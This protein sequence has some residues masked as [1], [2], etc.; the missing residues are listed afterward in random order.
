LNRL[1]A[2]YHEWLFYD[3]ENLNFGKPNEQREVSLFYGRDIESLQYAME[4]AP[5][6]NKRFAY[7]P[8][9]DEMLQSESTGSA[10]G[11]PDLVHAINA[12]NT[13]YSKTF[14]QPSLVRVDNGSDIKDHVEHEEKANI[15]NLLK[16]H[17]S[18]DNPEVGI[19]TIADITMS[20]K[21]DLSFAT[22]SLGKFLI[23][24]VT[25]TIDERGH[26][27]NTF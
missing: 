17:A 8:R 21:Q 27:H 15:S 20:L 13:M 11:R 5:I 1:S 6:K 24:S 14:N 16:I 19:G 9:Q 25:H 18:G 3:G 22:E 10:D 2:E 26:Y 7:N 4:V 12:S 23:T